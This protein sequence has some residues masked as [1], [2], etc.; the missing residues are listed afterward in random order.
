MLPME[1][2]S[3]LEVLS[4]TYFGWWSCIGGIHLVFQSPLAIHHAKEHRKNS[5]DFAN[6]CE[7]SN[8]IIL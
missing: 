5:S 3:G 4:S 1:N 8:A 6:T 7:I 2:S